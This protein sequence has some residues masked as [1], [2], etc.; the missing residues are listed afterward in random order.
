MGNKDLELKSISF[1]FSQRAIE[2]RQVLG[3][4]RFH[5]IRTIVLEG[6]IEVAHFTDEEA[7]YFLWLSKLPYFLKHRL[8]CF[9]EL[10]IYL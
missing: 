9:T 3:N 10:L 5:R 4:E 8:Y 6:S 7:F 1:C 2:D